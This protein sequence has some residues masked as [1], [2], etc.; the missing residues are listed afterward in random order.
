MATQ[1]E[2]SRADELVTAAQSDPDEIDLETV[3]ELFDAER[4]VGRTAALQAV[5]VLA[6]DEPERALRFADRVVERLEDDVLSVRSTAALAAMSLARERPETVVPA[7]PTLIDLLDEE[8]PLLRFRAAGALAPLTESHAETFVDRVD[9]LAALLVD[10]ATFD[11]DPKAI[12]TSDE[13]TAE[14]KQRQ[15]AMLEGRGSEIQRGK[16]RSRGTR[17]VVANVLVEVARI[18][19]E[20][21]AAVFPDIRAALS[22]D[23]PAVRGGAV[24][25]VR[26]VADRDPSA[27]DEA[28]DPLVELLDD[29][30]DFVRARAIRALGY[31]EATAAS[32]PLRELARTE[33]DED[34]AE[35]AADTADWLA[36][37]ERD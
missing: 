19:P 21:C 33:A 26:H 9:R 24:E 37:T 25:I 4:A 36:A 30:V 8:P 2:R 7:V 35:L 16:A 1:R 13:L 6:A 34:V 32:K 27:V 20:T 22:D 18:A 10:G 29:D 11:A 3:A 28:V 15:L 5:S 31:A 17:E 23:D 14:R 12:A